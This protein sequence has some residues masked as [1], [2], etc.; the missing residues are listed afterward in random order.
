MYRSKTLREILLDFARKESNWDL[1][2]AT[3]EV[4]VAWGTEEAKGL[5]HENEIRDLPVEYYHRANILRGAIEGKPG[6]REWV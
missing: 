4:L 1:K 5:L 2:L 6:Y 3:L